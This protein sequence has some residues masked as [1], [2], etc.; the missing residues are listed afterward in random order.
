MDLGTLN[1]SLKGVHNEG[2]WLYCLKKSHTL[3]SPV[4]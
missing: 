2:S 4:S 1:R 3:E